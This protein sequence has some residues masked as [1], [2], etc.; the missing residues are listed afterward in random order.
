MTGRSRSEAVLVRRVRALSRHL[1]AAVAGDAVGVHQAR[2]ASRRLR[3]AVPVL[4]LALPERRRTRLDRRLRRITRALGPIR[5]LDV[6]A[7][8][9]GDL[10]TGTPTPGVAAVLEALEARRAARLRTLPAR[11]ERA[12]PERVLERLSRLAFLVGDV[13]AAVWRGVLS[14]RTAARGRRLRD[15]L[16]H[17]GVLYAGEPLHAAR[18]AIKKLRYAAEL[19]GELR[20]APTKTAVREL[21]AAQETL[22]RLHDLDVLGAAVQEVAGAGRAHET[23]LARVLDRVERECRQLHAAYLD[24]R[25]RLIALADAATDRLAP[26]IRRRTAPRPPPAT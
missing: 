2:V 4:G 16:E 22:G 3:E 14:A 9:L 1:P 13:P 25:P 19:A 8:R 17:A 21:K 26:R 18:I 7:D 5:E 10:Y 6:S 12:R 11:L 20:V 23:E 24:Q 15:A